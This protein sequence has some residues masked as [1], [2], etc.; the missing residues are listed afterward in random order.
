MVSFAHPSQLALIAQICKSFVL[1]NGAFSA[2]RSGKPITDWLP[3]RYWIDEWRQHPACD[4]WLIPDVI[5]GDE[6]DNDQ[7]VFEFREVGGGVPI[8]HLHEHTDRLQRLI[9]MGFQRI[10]FGSSGAYAEIG[11]GHWWRRMGI[12]MAFCCD[13]KGRPLAKLHGLRML[14]PQIFT[15]FPFSSADS[16]NVARNV[17]LDGRW[18]GTYAPAGKAARGIVL[19]DR[20][21]AYQSCSVWDHANSHEQFAL[22]LMETANV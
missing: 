8:W 14:D 17:G 10:A 1:D 9:D 20:I 11:T 22:Q 5:D 15:R 4:W 6:R 16:T 12:A 19:A 21:E 7:L 3:F 2:W 18:P 13:S